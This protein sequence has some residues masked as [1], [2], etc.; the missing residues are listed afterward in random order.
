MGVKGLL[1]RCLWLGQ[2]LKY[3][4][5]VREPARKYQRERQGQIDRQEGLRLSHYPH[6]PHYHPFLRYQPELLCRMTE[7]LKKQNGNGC[8]FSRGSIAAGSPKAELLYSLPT[9]S[10]EP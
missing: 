10:I 7:A 4:V 8:S 1:R 6:F 2:E 3:Q 9:S 5:M